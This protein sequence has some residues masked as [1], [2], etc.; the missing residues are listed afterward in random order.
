[1]STSS[2]PGRRKQGTHLAVLDVRPLPAGDRSG[3]SLFFF[4]VGCS[5]AGFL[6][7]VA[8]GAVAPVLLPTFWHVLNRFWIGGAAF[9]AFRSIIYFG[10][11]GVGTDALKLLAWLGVGV[12]LLALPIW[13]KI[14][15]GRGRH[16]SA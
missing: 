15:P 4:L 10:G 6:T 5:V 12:V 3:E 11:Q 9:P 14:G 2:A 8:T 7:V 16:A 13:R 1:V